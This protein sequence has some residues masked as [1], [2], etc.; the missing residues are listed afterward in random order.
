MEFE[1]SVSRCKSISCN[2]I[3]WPA[4]LRADV[5]H[6]C[7][8]LVGEFDYIFSRDFLDLCLVQYFQ[9]LL[10]LI[11]NCI[12]FRHRLY[13]Y[14]QDS[15]TRVYTQDQTPLRDHDT[16][17][18][19]WLIESYHATSWLLLVMTAIGYTIK[20]LISLISMRRNWFSRLLIK[21]INLEWSS[22]KSILLIAWYINN[23]SNFGL[24]P[25]TPGI[26]YHFGIR[27]VV[28]TTKR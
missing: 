10:I 3:Q 7:L 16:C 26:A 12:N 8:S 17:L 15:D 1:Q 5:F 27:Q 20:S 19:I 21:R 28:K 4:H 6:D 22:V 9:F 18:A 2:W 25:Q 23:L 11:G 24:H 14:V 13:I